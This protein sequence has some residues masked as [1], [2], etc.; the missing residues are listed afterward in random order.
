M[1][2]LFQAAIA[3][4]IAITTVVGT[5]SV[6]N[7]DDIGKPTQVERQV[8]RMVASL[9]QKDH[10]STKPLDD[11]VSER[12]FDIYI[13]SL[14][15]MKVYF[16]K[17]DIDEFNQYRTKLDDQMKA[18]VYS[19]AFLIYNRFLERVDE[20]VAMVLEILDGE[21]D[22]TLD[23]EMVT[24]RDSLEFPQT[25][26]EAREIWRKRIKYNML[27][28]RGVQRD[29]KEKGKPTTEPK[30]KLRKRYTAYQN[31]M[32]Q[33][34]SE[35][36]VEMYLTSL[37]NAFD[38]HTSYMSKGSFENFL[39]AMSLELEGIGATL[40][41]TDDGYT[42]IKR[43]VPGGAA[44]KQGEMAVE[45]KIVSVAQGDNEAVDVTG[46]KLDDVVKL[47]RGKA[48]TT[49]RLGVMPENSTEIKTISIVREKIKLEDS[50]ARGDIFEEGTKADG[51]PYKIGVIDLPSF[52]ANMSSG[53]RGSSERRST[54]ADVKRI[55]DDFN[56]KGVDSVVLDL[57]RNGG[58]SLREAIDCTGLFIDRGPVVQVKDAYG[59]V[60]EHNDEQ[61]GMSWDKPLVVLT[62]KF[63]ASASE[64]LAG[65]VQDYGRG[66][67]V[68]DTTTHGKGTVQNLVNLSQLL[69]KIENP[70]NTFGALKITMQQF[71]RPNGDST[72]QRGVLSDVTLPSITDHMDVGESDLD[73]PVEFDRIKS[74]RYS[75]M[76]LV[77]TDI[78]SKLQ[79][80]S[81]MRISES[82]E[83]A[84]RIKNIE[85]YKKQKERKSVTLNEE[86]FIARRK[87]LDAEKED[88]S[89]IEDQV[90]PSD[91]IKRDYY[92]DEVLRITQDYL[93]FLKEAKIA[94]K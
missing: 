42:V 90:T 67:V 50:A 38:P 26:A 3:S 48:G 76:G 80:R 62:S 84:K 75:D 27:V 6:T 17:S 2:K 85:E 63:S 18:G 31:R 8:S 92:L 23:E 28:E 87:E 29:L 20:R 64:I 53:R 51:S 91:E 70:P 59:Q 55:L 32:H 47:I 16:L 69:F 21:F 4:L 13:K 94:Q 39:I 35:D 36:V 65:A 46:V 60:H 88:E 7:A 52:Y 49:V 57:R 79:D 40:S 9:M 25:D 54:T 10:L 24:D 74:T 14:D 30:E 34:D 56:R 66:I 58:G 78:L 83:F 72:Q 73:Y 86:K 44:D 19:A 61:G 12:A 15:P 41:T 5:S 93:N 82:E 77:K 11:G 1:R 33:T 37:T 22:F 81:Q 71:Y 45:D 89:Q 68:G 43:V